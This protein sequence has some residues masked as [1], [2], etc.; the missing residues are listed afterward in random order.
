MNL[1]DKL[2]LS[3][4][5]LPGWINNLVALTRPV[6]L[7]MTVAM[8][9]LGAAT[10]G[11]VAFKYP[12]TA[13]AMARASSTFLQ[14]IPTEGWA[15]VTAIALGYTAS[16]TAEVIKAKAPPLGRASPEGEPQPAAP[17]PAVDDVAEEPAPVEPAAPPA[18]PLPNPSFGGTEII[19]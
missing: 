12:Q 11:L 2:D 3:H 6:A 19:E 17:A 16:K 7:T 15:A 8:P 9:P 5:E 10:V 13:M 1:F 14:G 18:R 4:G